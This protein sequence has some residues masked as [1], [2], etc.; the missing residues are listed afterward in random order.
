MD[1]EINTFWNWFEEKKSLIEKIVRGEATDKRNEI[2]DT[3]D[4]Y[5]LGFGKIKWIIDQPSSEEFQLVL[6]PNRDQDTWEFTKSIISEAPAM[7]NW[8]FLDAIPPNGQFIFDIYDDYM[9]I[10]TIQSQNWQFG[11]VDLPTD[12]VNLLISPSANPTDLD[13]ENFQAAVNIGLTNVLG[14]AMFMRLIQQIEITE[15]ENWSKKANRMNLEDLA[16]KLNKA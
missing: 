6:S 7:L 12:A 13:P 15:E 10:H 2:I 3:L 1:K 16:T 5:I 9:N 8:R 4:E 11:V 14:E